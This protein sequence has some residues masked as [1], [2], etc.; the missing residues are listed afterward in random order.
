MAEAIPSLRETLDRLQV[1]SRDRATR[2]KNAYKDLSM[3]ENLSQDSKRTARMAVPAKSNAMSKET[4]VAPETAGA[5]YRI[6]TTSTTSEPVVNLSGTGMISSSLAGD[7]LTSDP[8]FRKLGPTHSGAPPI[9][10]QDTVLNGPLDDKFR[11][12]RINSDTTQ[13]SMYIRALST[14]GFLGL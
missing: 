3:S 12:A 8:S 2:L 10:D 5:V 13:E 14:F 7:Q 9:Q 6:S 1:K 11:S 4:D